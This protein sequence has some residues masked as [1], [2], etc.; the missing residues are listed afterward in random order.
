MQACLTSCALPKCTEPL[1]SENLPEA[2]DDSV[3]RRLARSSCHLQPGFDDIGRGHQRRRRYALFATQRH[4]EAVWVCTG[5][6]TQRPKW[7]YLH[8]VMGRKLSQ[9][10]QSID[11]GK[12]QEGNQHAFFLGGFPSR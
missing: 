5:G 1:L 7:L 3:V 6:V 2:V 12:Q 4:N 11:G 8:G 9:H 10:S